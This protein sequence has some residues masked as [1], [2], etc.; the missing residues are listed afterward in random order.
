MEALSGLIE[1]SDNAAKAHASAASKSSRGWL[2]GLTLCALIALSLAS[3][4]IIRSITQPL[5]RMENYM[6]ELSQGRAI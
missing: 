2:V 4:F 5:Q 6:L 3:Y 1:A